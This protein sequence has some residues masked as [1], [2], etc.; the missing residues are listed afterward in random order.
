LQSGGLGVVL[1]QFSI[2][3]PSPQMDLEFLADH[4]Q[5][6][7]QNCVDAMFKAVEDLRQN[8]K[9]THGNVELLR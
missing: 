8:K 3:K 4:P 7:N 5:I 1:L 6:I 2:P 9:T